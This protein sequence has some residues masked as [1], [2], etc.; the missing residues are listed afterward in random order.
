[1]KSARPA[2]LPVE[3]PNTLEL[4]VILKIANALG[5]AVPH[6]ILQRAN[7]EID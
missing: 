6:S 7:C 3:T 4:V 5:L 2:D 1:M